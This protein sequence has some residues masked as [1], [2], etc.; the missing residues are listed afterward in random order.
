MKTTEQIARDCGIEDRTHLKYLR[1]LLDGRETAEEFM[2]AEVI[3]AFYR[4][5]EALEEE[6]A[7]LLLAAQEAASAHVIDGVLARRVKLSAETWKGDK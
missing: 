2:A 4:R 3:G 1:R 6:N 5:I 7:A